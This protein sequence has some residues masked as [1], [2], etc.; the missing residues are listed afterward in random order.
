MSEIKSLDPE[1]KMIHLL[2]SWTY[3]SI[4]E[5]TCFIQWLIMRTYVASKHTGIILRTMKRMANEVVHSGMVVIQDVT[6]L[7]KWASNSNMQKIGSC[8][9]LKE[10]EC[11]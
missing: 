7:F 1:V 5:Q 10:C 4:Q 9:W 6:D 11:T 3:K 8:L 2:D